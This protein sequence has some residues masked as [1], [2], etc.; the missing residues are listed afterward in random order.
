MAAIEFDLELQLSAAGG[1]KT[2][3]DAAAGLSSFS[4]DILNF[5]TMDPIIRRNMLLFLKGI[6][7]GQRGLHGKS[8][9]GGTSDK[10]LSRRTGKL[11]ESVEAS[12]RVTGKFTAGSEVRGQI[13]SPLIYASTQE[14]GAT[15]RPKRAQYL[16]VPLPAALDNRGVPILP[17]ARD[18][19][20]TFVQR[21]RRGNLIIFQKRG[22]NKIV[23]LYVL[24]KQ[25]TIPPRMNLRTMIEAGNRGLGDRIINEAVREFNLGRI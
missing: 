17:R 1:R 20:R 14:F 11:I 19:P 25:V 6:A 7:A 21:S 4:R 24:K 9:P 8:W 16:T 2:F 18:W 13:G 3:R 5:E 23:P 22:A 15:I 10:S 12:I